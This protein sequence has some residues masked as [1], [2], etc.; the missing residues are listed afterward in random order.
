MFLLSVPQV[1]VHGYLNPFV[2]GP[3]Q[4]R[5]ITARKIAYLMAARKQKEKERGRGEGARD[6]IDPLEGRPQ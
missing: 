6:K 2:L 3:W 1:S 4:G 5:N